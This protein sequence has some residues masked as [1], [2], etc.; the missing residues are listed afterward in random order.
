MIHCISS[1]EEIDINSETHFDYVRFFMSQH[2]QDSFDTV[3]KWT[4]V[5][6]MNNLTRT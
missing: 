1:F 6:I 3:V 5:T 2:V 4:G